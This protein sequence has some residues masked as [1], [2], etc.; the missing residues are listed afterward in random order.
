MRIL[1]DEFRYYGVLQHKF[2]GTL[3]TLLDL[4]GRGFLVNDGSDHG[5]DLI[6]G[7]GSDLYDTLPLSREGMR[8]LRSNWRLRIE[9]PRQYPW[10]TTP[11]PEAAS[12]DE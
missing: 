9:R 5:I 11:S 12:R 3:G 1:N 10:L 8:F 7:N 6:G 4:H 2:A